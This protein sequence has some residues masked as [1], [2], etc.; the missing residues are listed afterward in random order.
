MRAQRFIVHIDMDAYFAS[1]ESQACPFLSGKPLVVGA[2]PGSR[3]V[4][5]SA[6][7]EAREFGIRAGMP[8]TQALR[9]CPGLEHV[10]CHPSLYIH[11][12]SR[13]MKLLLELTTRVE[14]FSIDEAFLDITDLISASDGGAAAWRRAQELAR[15]LSGMIESRFNLTCSIGI[16]PNK[17]LAKMASKMKK[18]RGVTAL[19]QR[20]FR[21]HFSHRPVDDLY[22]V[23][24]KTAA[25]LMIFGIE[26]IGE[27]AETPV[28][29]LR[30]RFGVYGDALHAMSRGEDDSHVVAL[31][32]S[33]PAKSMGH[34]HTLQRDTATL[35]EGL[36]L[37]LSL[38][39]RVSSDLRGEGLAGRRVAI[40]MR[41][42]D[43][44]TLT[45]QRMLSFPS[46]ETRDVYRTAK[47]LFL[48]NYCGDGI[49]LLGVTVGELMAT[50][51][52]QQMGLFPEDRRYRDYLEAVDQV[53]NQFGH[54]SL[55]VAGGLV[56]RAQERTA[57]R[58]S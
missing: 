29:F 20:A 13:I 8:V 5:A 23:G 43:F 58:F 39:E 41:Y 47:A 38:A 52:R 2:M 50:G 25:S 49:R 57:S 7:Y 51:G 18:P 46:Q 10:P 33:P 24:E 37:L 14:M 32:E 42:A 35:D 36:A 6:S 12:S 31:H 28:E 54:E 3:G 15:E 19:T 16:G 45:R 11:T 55:R 53:R 30:G 34:E 27:L 1:L 26:R 56:V 17:L 44:S 22:G 9:I 48:G 4:V 21:S 40:K